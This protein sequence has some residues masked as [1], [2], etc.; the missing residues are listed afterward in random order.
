M[1][2]TDQLKAEIK[3]LADTPR[4]H[5]SGMAAAIRKEYKLIWPRT[6]SLDELERYLQNTEIAIQRELDGQASSQAIVK[7]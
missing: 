4:A 2:T 6:W 5:T 7:G 1:K 3:A